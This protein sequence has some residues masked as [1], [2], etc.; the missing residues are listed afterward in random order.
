MAGGR[1]F[2]RDVASITMDLNGVERIQFNALGGADNITVNDLTGTDVKQVTINLAG[3][4]GGSGGDG[5]R[6]PFPSTRPTARRSRSP[7]T[8]A[9]SRCRAWPAP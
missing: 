6:T 3:T 7:T 2:T 1:L 4:L 9:W 5:T 8:T